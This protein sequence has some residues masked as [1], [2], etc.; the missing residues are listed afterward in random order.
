MTK[1]KEVTLFNAAGHTGVDI[2]HIAVRV[3]PY[4]EIIDGKPVKSHRVYIGTKKG[5][6]SASTPTNFIFV[7]ASKN[8]VFHE[9]ELDGTTWPGLAIY[10]QSGDFSVKFA[11][12]EKLSVLLHDSCKVFY[13]HRYQIV[14][15]N[16]ITGELATCDPDT[17]NSDG[18]GIT[19]GG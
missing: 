8:W 13:T 19:G 5:D 7:C 15:R 1:H 10:P 9:F 6:Y 17:S 11:D 16:S 3:Y 14:L 2:R 18:E 12:S 4:L